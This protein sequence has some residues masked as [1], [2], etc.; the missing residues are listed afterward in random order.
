[1]I[2]IQDIKLE[3]HSGQPKVKEMFF[4]GGLHMTLECKDTKLWPIFWLHQN[5]SLYLEG[6]SQ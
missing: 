1:M 5:V 4:Y 3:T 6:Q 2:N